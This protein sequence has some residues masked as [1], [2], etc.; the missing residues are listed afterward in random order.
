M[1]TTYHYRKAVGAVASLET[2]EAK[3][4]V[5]TAFAAVFTKDHAG[6]NPNRFRV[7]CG[8]PTDVDGGEPKEEG[9]GN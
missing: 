9:D 3:E 8:L 7:A 2:T 4:T 5:A 6:F 1:M